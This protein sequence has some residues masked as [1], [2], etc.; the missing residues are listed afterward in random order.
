MIR[1]LF[2]IIAM[3]FLLKILGLLPF[4]HDIWVQIFTWLTHQNATAPTK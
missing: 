3:L 1:W 4:V 2:A